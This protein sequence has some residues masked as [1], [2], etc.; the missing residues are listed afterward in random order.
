MS[1]NSKAT[2]AVA[3]CESLFDRMK[4]AVAKS[5]AE[6]KS[7]IE[8][9]VEIASLKKQRKDLIMELGEKTF[10]EMSSY[11]KDPLVSKIKETQKKLSELVSG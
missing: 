9:E 5:T 1:A 8:K 7:A 6:A 11:S 3:I 10:R 2:E 4:T